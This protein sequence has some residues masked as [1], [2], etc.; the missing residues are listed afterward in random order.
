L[1]TSHTRAC[2]TF[3]LRSTPTARYTDHWPNGTRV[4]HNDTTQAK[5]D[6]IDALLAQSFTSRQDAALIAEMLSLPND[7][8]YPTLELPPQQRRQKTL[9]ALAAQLEALSR[10]NPVLMIF[11]D[12]HWIDPTSL[13]VLGRSV[14]RLKTLGVLLI[15]TYRPEFEPPWIGRPYVS[16]LGLNRLGEREIT[17]MI[18]RV[19]GNKPLAESVR[20]DIV[21]RTDGIPLF[22]EEMTKA[23]LEAESEGDARKTA[24]AVPSSTIAVPASLHASLMARLDRLGSAKEMAQ[25]GAAIGREFSHALLAAVIAK[26]ET[27]LRSSLDR[28]ISAGLLFR[29]GLA[30]HA[31]YLFKHALV[32]DAA[33]GTLLREPRRALHARIAETIEDDFAEIAENQPELLARHCTEAGLKAT[34]ACSWIGNFSPPHVRVSPNLFSLA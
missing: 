21:E 2:A 13:E 12:V 6:K 8:R 32:Q 1:L 15:V 28:L 10:S 23:V 17:E 22:V 14:E 16:A 3:A 5:L 27:E 26:P 31:S 29:Q 34:S 11:E 9:E 4:A 7:G 20:Q 19:T 25:I 24:A 18:D 30:P 33:Y